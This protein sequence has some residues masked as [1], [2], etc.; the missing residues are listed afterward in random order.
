[1]LKSRRKD[2]Q[3]MKI[4]KKLLLGA[5]ILILLSIG[6]V[7]LSNT[8]F[9]TKLELSC[10]G[11]FIEILNGKVQSRE[12]ELRAVQIQIT[13]IPFRKQYVLASSG[14][15]LI[16]SSEADRNTDDKVTMV[17]ANDVDVIAGRRY[18]TKDSTVFNAI[19]L[20]RITKAVKVETN[21]KRL[22]NGDYREDI[23]SGVCEPVKRL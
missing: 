7:V 17:M 12:K 8:L 2:A 3:E 13:E 22:P 1:V 6:L 11:E 4:I 19:T 9:T 10:T 5:L 23:F 20:N 14:S 21:G 16:T 15:I 18:T